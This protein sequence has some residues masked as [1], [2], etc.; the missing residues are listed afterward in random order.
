MCAQKNISDGAKKSIVRNKI[1]IS[2]CCRIRRV[3]LPAGFDEN[4]ASDNRE[5]TTTEQKQENKMK[6]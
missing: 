1:Q 5:S 6:W 4:S 2:D 3:R